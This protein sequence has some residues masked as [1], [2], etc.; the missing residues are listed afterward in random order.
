MGIISRFVNLFSTPKPLAS[1]PTLIFNGAPLTSDWKWIQATDPNV[2]NRY[3]RWT[4]YFT[5]INNNKLNILQATLPVGSSLSNNQWV[6]DESPIISPTEGSW[7]SDATETASY[8]SFVDKNGKFV[9]RIYYTGW[10]LASKNLDGKCN[11]QIGMVEKQFD[12]WVKYPVS[13]LK[14]ELP[15]EQAG[16]LGSILGD[17]SVVYQNGKFYM[18]YQ[19]GSGSKTILAVAK[20]DDGI[21][22]PSNQR[23]QII[24]KP[25]GYPSNMPSGPYHVSVKFINNKWYFIGWLSNSNLNY[26]GIYCGI[27][28]IENPS[29][30]QKINPLLFENQAAWM[31][32][33]NTIMQKLHEL[34]LF[35]SDVV[36]ENGKWYLFFHVVKRM[37]DNSNNFSCIGVSS[38]N[39][40]FLS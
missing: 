19:V 28:S 29:S 18:F 17:Q 10:T 27:S 21:N 35:G 31:K 26:Q 1:N 3:N 24:T 4:M 14:A 9:E 25:S 15:W 34:G 33:T 38:L 32:P 30:Y 22:W 11:Y 39:S 36:C 2:V 20:S 23:Y 12:N 13:V 5:S 8:I 7:D 16:S 40:T 37:P 6:V